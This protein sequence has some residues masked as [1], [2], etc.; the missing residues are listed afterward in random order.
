MPA[1]RAAPCGRPTRPEQCFTSKRARAPSPRSCASNCAPILSPIEFV[2]STFA[3][4]IAAQPFLTGGRPHLGNFV[5]SLEGGFVRRQLQP[6][7]FAPS[8]DVDVGLD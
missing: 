3:G 6:R 4:N 2:P 5:E 8:E 1:G 7:Q